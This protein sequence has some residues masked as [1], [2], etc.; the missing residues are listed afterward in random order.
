ML[1]ISTPFL[2]ALGY[3]LLLLSGCAANGTFQYSKD[4]SGVVMKDCMPNYI[5][6][7][8]IDEASII[9]PEEGDMPLDVNPIYTGDKTVFTFEA[10]FI[11]D[12]DFGDDE[13][14]NRVQFQLDP[15]VKHFYYKDAELEKINAYFTHVAFSSE[16]GYY[17]IRKGII[18]GHQQA[19]GSWSIFIYFDIV[20]VGRIPTKMDG[21]YEVTFSAS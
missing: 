16:Q 1:K 9:R 3:T 17:P 15:G 12:P 11:D 6:R 2:F 21:A 7:T 13:V 14:I 19:D 18:E 4:Y 20:T 5:C 10:E 8:E